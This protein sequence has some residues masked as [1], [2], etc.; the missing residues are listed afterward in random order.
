MENGTNI[1]QILKEQYKTAKNLKTRSLLH[2]YNT[3]KIDWNNWCFSQMQIPNKAKILELGC[4]TGDLWYENRHFIKNDWN[5]TLSDFSSGMLE[6]T[7]KNLER[8]NYNFSYEEIDAQ[9]I[10]YENE[11]FDIIIARH[12]LYLVPEIEK[13]LSEIKRVLVNGGIFYV[14]TNSHDSMSELNTLVEKFD[15][16]MGLHNNGMCHR[17][18]MEGGY[19]LLKKYFSQVKMDVLQGNIV[20]DYAEPIVTYKASTI[21]GTSVLI[22]NKRQQFTE[23]LEDYIK[24]NGSISITTKSC[25]FKAKK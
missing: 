8:V 19:L 20:V 10:P 2:S 5:I 4:G 13:A 7:R 6:N 23:Y 3:N 15:S 17:F 21:K 22:G 1:K 16:N 25:I 18:N 9:D 12:M 24:K 11:Y 14:T